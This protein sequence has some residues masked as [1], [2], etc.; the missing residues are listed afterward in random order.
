MPNT[1]TGEK[2]INSYRKNEVAK[3]KEK[4]LPVVNLSGG[5]ST[6]LP[7]FK[8]GDHGPKVRSEKR[9]IK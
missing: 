8:I 5:K 4:K 9:I 3:P 2:W 7:F 6:P 1:L